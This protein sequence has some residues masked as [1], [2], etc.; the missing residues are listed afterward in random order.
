MST[1]YPDKW[2]L[3]E[4]DSPQHGKI[5]KV[6]SSNYGGYLGGDSWKLSSGINKI[7]VN[8]EN[9][10]FTNDSGSVYIC[11]KNTYGMSSY[12]MS[13]YS[14]FVEQIKEAND[15]STIRILDEDKVDEAVLIV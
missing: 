7:V 11:H 8:K 6:M 10:E 13:V 14:N 2:V 15:G 3:V 1:Y 4:F 5:T 12:A 9:Y